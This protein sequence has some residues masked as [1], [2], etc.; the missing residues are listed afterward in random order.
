[1]MGGVGGEAGADLMRLE[2]G[3]QSRWARGFLY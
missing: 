2:V 1:M 3:S